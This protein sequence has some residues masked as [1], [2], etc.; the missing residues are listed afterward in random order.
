MSITFRKIEEKDNKALAGLIRNV[1]EEFNIEKIG[2]VYSDPTTDHLSEVFKNP[3][4]AYWL[5][6]ED[7]VLLGGCGIFPTE[8]LPDGCVELVKFYLSPA[9][10]GKGIGKKLMEKSIESAQQL[11]YNEVYLESFPELSTAIGLYEKAGFKAL[12]GPLGNS[13]HFACNVWMLLVL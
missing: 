6:E 4:A 7:G 9:S 12:S 11:G 2:T 3:K 8:G 1:F 13:G 5:A 10:R